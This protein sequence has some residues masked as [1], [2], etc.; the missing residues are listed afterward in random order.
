[1]SVMQVVSR[2]ME[3]ICNIKIQVNLT[4]NKIISLVKIKCIGRKEYVKL[5]FQYLNSF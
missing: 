1:M 2:P 5:Q 4:D 3:F